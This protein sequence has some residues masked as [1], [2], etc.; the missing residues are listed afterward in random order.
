MV[1]IMRTL[2]TQGIKKLLKKA[3]LNK[4]LLILQ[5][6]ASQHTFQ[7]LLNHLRTHKVLALNKMPTPYLLQTL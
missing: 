7:K 1:I 5:T 6:E 4:K 2:E 3:L